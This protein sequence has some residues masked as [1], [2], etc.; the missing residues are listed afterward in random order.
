M[1]TIYINNSFNQSQFFFVKSAQSGIFIEFQI[2]LFDV[3]IYLIG[4]LGIDC[5]QYLTLKVY[6]LIIIH[7]TIVL[8]TPVY[9][10]TIKY[11]PHQLITH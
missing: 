10:L 8:C 1:A 11:S 2:F 6:I 9:F 4:N 3:P 7:V 5:Q